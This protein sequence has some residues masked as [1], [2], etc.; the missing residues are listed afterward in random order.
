MNDK[1][2]GPMK[3]RYAHI[4]QKASRTFKALSAAV[5]DVPDASWHG[6]ITA[7]YSKYPEPEPKCT[8]DTAS[9]WP[10]EGADT[11][12]YLTSRQAP[13]VA[14]EARSTRDSTMS[15]ADPKK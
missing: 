3:R 14:V 1:I 8:L 11:A 4:V 6:D 13:E 10:P 12:R 5:P 9:V 15:E 2:T 7:Q